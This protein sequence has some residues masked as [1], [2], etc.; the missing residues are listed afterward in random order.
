MYFSEVLDFYLAHRPA[1]RLFNANPALG[2]VLERIPA[3]QPAGARAVPSSAPATYGV[4]DQLPVFREALLNRLTFP[5]A[6]NPASDAGFPE[7]RRQARAKVLECLLTPP[8]RTDFAPVVVAREDR[9]SY[10]A[11]RLVFNVSADCRVP[12]YLLV[13]K[14]AGPFPAVIA[15]HD[16]GAFFLIGKEKMI[17]PFDARPEIVEAARTWVGKSYGGRFVG[18]A[19]AERG[20]VVF[21]MDALYWGDRGRREGV[22]HAQQQALA[23]NLMLM[24]TTW[25]GTITW[26]DVRSA[27]FVASL[28]HVDPQRIGAIGLSMGCHRTW[29]LHALSDRI[30]AAAGVCWMCTTDALMTPGNNQTKGQSAYSM[31]APNLRNFIDYSDV[32]AIACPKPLLLFDGGEKDTLF[33]VRGVDAAYARLRRVWDSQAAGEKL[34]TRRWDVGHVFDLPMQDTA[35]AWLDR[36]LKKPAG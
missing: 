30:T 7:W 29:M 2:K 26:D 32:A 10:E 19:L 34:V 23:S 35:F 36:W 13:P 6:W 14:G 16:H 3:S 21:S 31:L 12:A 15:L 4:A 27:E 9:G 5:L 20:Y 25:L 1:E 28:P 17:R 8:P 18:D 33:P 11:Q 24:G 22:D